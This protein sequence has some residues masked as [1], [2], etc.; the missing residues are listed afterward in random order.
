L[1][2]HQ[3]AVLAEPTFAGSSSATLALSKNSTVVKTTGFTEA[4]INHELTRPTMVPSIS[5]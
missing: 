2:V 3:A 5:R 1:T 4:E